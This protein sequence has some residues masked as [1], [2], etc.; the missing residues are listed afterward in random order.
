MMPIRDYL[1][2]LR[3]NER[4]ML[5]SFLIVAVAL[6][7]IFFL[8]FLRRSLLSETELARSTTTATFLNSLADAH[9]AL[10]S[11]LADHDA[12]VSP[13]T[14]ANLSAGERFVRAIERGAADSLILLN[15]EGQP[16][17]PA[18]PT[19]NP[20][21]TERDREAIEVRQELHNAANPQK[22]WDAIV[23]GNPHLT[24]ARDTSGRLI[25]PS[26]QLQALV[27]GRVSEGNRARVLAD[28]ERRI[29]YFREPVLPSPQRLFLAL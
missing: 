1:R 24:D 14:E 19:A 7:T 17:F 10:E 28:L 2:R 29:L 4:W 23:T 25:I 11:Y 13:P 6:P 16:L 8:F 18:L 15:D 20:K 9:E 22:S 12:L 27:S 3:L 26:L 21:L 5:M